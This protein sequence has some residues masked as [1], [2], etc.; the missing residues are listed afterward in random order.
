MDLFSRLLKE[1][2]MFVGD[3]DERSTS[4]ITN[5]LLYLEATDSEAPI[6]MYINRCVCMCLGL[7]LEGI[8]G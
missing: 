7:S 1:R 6:Q 2:V 3:I 4:L 8:V 5:Q